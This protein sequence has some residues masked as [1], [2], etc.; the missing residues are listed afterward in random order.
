MRRCERRSQLGGLSIVLVIEVP[1]HVVAQIPDFMQEWCVPTAVCTVDQTHGSTEFAQ[2]PEHRQDGCD[3][4]APATR[5]VEAAASSGAEL[6]RVF[7]HP[8][9]WTASQRLVNT[10]PV[11]SALSCRI[12]S[13]YRPVSIRV[14]KR[15]AA[16]HTALAGGCVAELRNAPRGRVGQNLALSF[17]LA[18][19]L[20]L[21]HA[22]RIG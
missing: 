15:I 5:T 14:A 2:S 9:R 22:Y 7:A 10:C 18:S 13:T 1:L 3:A 21:M 6:L 19:Q 17:D 8:W 16:H 11:L 12:P 4:N 20:C